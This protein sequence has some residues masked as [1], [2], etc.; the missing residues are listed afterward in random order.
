MA[1]Q[2]HSHRLQAL[3]PPMLLKTHA[4]LMCVSRTRCSTCIN[5]TCYACCGSSLPFGFQPTEPIISRHIL[6]CYLLFVR[7]S[8][9]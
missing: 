2:D 7:L 8:L 4:G 5:V 3:N 9:A 6:N 1:W